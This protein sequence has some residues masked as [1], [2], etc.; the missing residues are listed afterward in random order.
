MSRMLVDG[1]SLSGYDAADGLDFVNH[2][3]RVAL[4]FPAGDGRLWPR[5]A[6][7]RWPPQPPAIR[8]DRPRSF[9][10]LLFDAGNVF[11][12]DLSW[13][14]GL[15]QLLKRQGL[16]I[17]AEQFDAAWDGQF[18]E[19]VYIGARPLD[20]ALADMLAGWGLVSR[21]VDEILASSPARG[22]C[23]ADARPLT[24]VRDAVARLHQAGVRIG[25]IYNAACCRAT[26]EQQLARYGLTPCLS[27]VV[28]SRDVG[29]A[30]PHALTYA[31]ALAELQLP[32]DRVGFVGHDAHR[33]AGAGTAGMFTVAF[34]CG[35][36]VA[37]SQHL[38]H[39]DALVQFVAQHR[40][41]A[42][43]QVA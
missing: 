13:R 43:G 3:W 9:D 29:L 32:P 28:T 5:A 6:I 16:A 27:A 25:V 33:L 18:A 37:A 8:V 42:V 31:R 24:G 10:G 20:D 12:D 34:N 14:R 2:G 15:L 11:F 39:F 17:Q 38:P 23:D 26:L 22:A 19:T 4:P 40:R 1:D 21:Q 30:M 36:E 41:A 7:P 35:V